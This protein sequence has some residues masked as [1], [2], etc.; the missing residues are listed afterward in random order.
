[1]LRV[2]GLGFRGWGLG[3]KLIRGSGVE[4]KIQA[5]TLVTVGFRAWG[6]GFRVGWC[7][8]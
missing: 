2:S 7:K 8:V 6:L 1:M 5:I 4:Q 3:F